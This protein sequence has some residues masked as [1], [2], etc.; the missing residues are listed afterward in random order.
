M[1]ADLQFAVRSSGLFE[2]SASFSFAGIH[3]SELHIGSSH[4]IQAIKSCW[5]STKYS[6]FP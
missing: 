6:T 3:D 1:G 4:I 2:D 5:S